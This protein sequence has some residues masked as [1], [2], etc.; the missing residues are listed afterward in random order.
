VALFFPEGLI[1]SPDVFS[2][3][4]PCSVSRRRFLSRREDVSFA[5]CSTFTNVSLSSGYIGVSQTV[6]RGTLGFHRTSLGVP[7]EIVE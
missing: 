7:R 3:S 1:A 6:F 2:G 4:F 5:V